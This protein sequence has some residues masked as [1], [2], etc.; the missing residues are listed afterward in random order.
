MLKG[1]LELG[2]KTATWAEEKAAYLVTVTN[3][4]Q[5]LKKIDHAALN[6]VVQLENTQNQVSLIDKTLSNLKSLVRSNIPPRISFIEISNLF[7]L[8]TEPISLCQQSGAN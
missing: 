1:G 6:G 7:Q 3:L 8:G 2:E 4:D 5:P